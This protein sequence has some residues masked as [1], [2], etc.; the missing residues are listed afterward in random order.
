M[1]SKLESD[2]RDTVAWGTNRLVGFNAGKTQLVLFD[3]SNNTDAVDVK[4]GGS[5]FQEK[6]SIKIMGLTFSSKLNWGSLLINV[7]PRKLEP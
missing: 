6:S 1:A 4:M 7:P 5:V 3:R 2:L